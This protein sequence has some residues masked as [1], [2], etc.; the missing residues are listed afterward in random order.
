LRIGG[1]TSQKISK[2]VAIGGYLAYGI[3][4]ERWKYRGDIVFTPHSTDQ[5]RFTYLNDLAIPGQD[6]LD[7][8][9]DKIFYSLY[10]SRTKN[11]S[12]QKIGQFSYETEGLRPFSLKLYAKYTYDQP[13]GIVKYEKLINGQQTI[14]NDITTSEIGFFLRFAP[15]E[16]YFRIKGKRVLFHSPDVDIRLNHR[17]GIKDVLGSDYGY[18]ITDATIFKSF[19]FPKNTGSFGF[20]LSGGKVWNSVPFPLLFIPAGNQSY[21]YE[22]SS[23]NLMLYYE[24]ITDRFV[25]GNAN[26]QL[27]WTPVKILFKKSK[28]KTHAGIK[29]IYGP[30]SNK[31]NPEFHPELFIF[32]NGV[33]ALGDKVYTEANIGLSGILK[34]LRID[35]VYLLT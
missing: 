17:T 19:D 16:K 33:E 21:V 23:Y 15:N 29:A 27:N 32:N 34:Y 11:M 1:T 28:M 9:R 8:K 2:Y 14:I 26:I 22:A 13:L 18:N 10:Q 30:I 7:D 6:C 24:F 12:L 3:K 4:D 5:L 35:Y 25:A 20:S 31:N